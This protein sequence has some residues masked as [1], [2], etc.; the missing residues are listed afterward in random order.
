MASDADQDMALT[1]AEPIASIESTDGSDVFGYPR[2][3]LRRAQWLSL[4]G[5]WDFALDVRGELA[6]PLEVEWA[7]S[8]EVP[9]APET[10]AS[11]VEYTGFFRACW[12][13][14][15]FALS[16]VPPAQRVILHFGAV[17]YQARV[18]VDSALVGEH[19][20]GYTP[21]EIDITDFL[22]ESATHTLVVHASDDPVEL[23]KPRG[24]QDWRETPHAIWYLRTSG[25]WQTVWI[26]IVP[27]VRLRSLR[28]TPNLERWE[29]SC[30]AQ[31]FTCGRDDLRLSVKLR[32]GEELLSDDSYR[33]IA[34]EVHRRIGFSDPGIDEY[35]N[36][37]LW[38]PERP[39]L[40]EAELSVWGTRG[41]LIDQ[42]Q[43]YTALRTI[44]IQ[45]DRLVLNGRPSGLRLVLDQG[46]WP[47]GGMTAPDAALRRD[48]ELAKRMGFNGVRKH[49]KIESPRYLYWADRLG[50]FVWEEM[51]ST[52]RFTPDSIVRLT[53][54]WLDVLR[55]DVSHPCIIAW[56][57]MNE[58]WGVPN[59]PDSRAE[60]HFV[61]ALWHLTKTFDPTRPVVGNDGWESVATDLIGIHDYDSDLDRIARRYH[62]DQLRLRLFSQERPGGRMLA[63]EQD[64]YQDLKHPLVLSEFGGIALRSNGTWG[65]TECDSPAELESR[66][67]GLMRTVHRIEL[68][69]GFCYTQ[70]ADTYQEANGL[71]YADR[72]PKF[73]IERIAAATLNAPVA[74]DRREEGTRD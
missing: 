61:Q 13:R 57:P 30:D 44:A 65:Y 1:T 23:A 33:V 7:R 40:I 64:G 41:E 62:A 36:E 35:R 47:E 66:Y 26:E 68:L 19:Q 37:L 45:Q 46:Y 32:A 21:F 67:V 56:V 74:S 72:E 60:R 3:Q 6:S 49:Q 71:L 12:Y 4:N 59:L 31:L 42:V 63:L 10:P 28:W 24:K 55:R 17:D 69:S 38:S 25:I 8:I 39:I 50:L 29:I 14:R 16:R 48:V 53:R 20:G 43:S 15:E 27:A 34:G 70:F 51:P 5:R 58:S 2:P 11:G 54:E 52:Y 18:W 73:P 9:Y 22:S